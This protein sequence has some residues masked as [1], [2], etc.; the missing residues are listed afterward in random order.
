[1]RRN[2]AWVGRLVLAAA[3]AYPTVGIVWETAFDLALT[4]SGTG[5]ISPWNGLDSFLVWLLLPSVLWP[6][7]MS[8]F[9]PGGSLVAIALFGGMTALMFGALTFLAPGFATPGGPRRPPR[10][11]SAPPARADTPRTS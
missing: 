1:M 4:P 2:V 7:S 10:R 11:R 6:W 8:E 9:I 5:E 3:L